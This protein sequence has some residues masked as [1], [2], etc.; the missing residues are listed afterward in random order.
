MV[1]RVLGAWRTGRLTAAGGMSM[2]PRLVN[3]L[4]GL[5]LM[6]APAVLDY[7][8]AA[9]TNDR[10]VGPLAASFAVIAIWEVTRPL[11]W[12]NVALGVWLLVAPWLLGADRAPLLNETA[13]GLVLIAM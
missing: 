10:I 4:V 11:R 6:A 5:W 8:G 2:W 1:A 12:A 13:A 9:R 3:T 7:A